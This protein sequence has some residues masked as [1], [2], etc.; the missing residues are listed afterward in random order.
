MLAKNKKFLF[1]LSILLITAMACSFSS[2][3]FGLAGR[4]AETVVTEEAVVVQ[5]APEATAEA[6]APIM[7]DSASV[8]AINQLTSGIYQAVSPGVVSILV[9]T[10][11]GSG[12]GS[13]FVYDKEGHIVTN[14]HVVDGAT[15][16][17]VDFQSGIKVW[18]DI[19]ATDPDSDLA[20]IKVDV[21]ADEL[22]P[23]TL[24]SSNDL[25]VGDTVL[26]IGNPYGLVGT[27]TTG[28]VSAKGRTMESQRLSTSGGYFSTGDIIQTDAS[29]NP[30][31]SGGPLLN[32]KGEVVGINRAIQTSGMTSTGDPVNTGIGFAISVDIVKRVVPVLI[33]NG[34]YEYPYLGISAL[35]EL[36]LLQQELLGITNNTGAYVTD[37]VA[38]SPADT[39]GVIGATATMVDYQGQQVEMPV[40]GDLIIAIDDQPVQVFG[41]LLSYILLNKVPGDT[42]TLTVIRGGETQTLSLVLGSRSSISN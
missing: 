40:G 38:G 12:S 4:L 18:A 36:N 30:G 22:V 32:L 23:L 33:S 5:E 3:P 13:G 2:L 37:V 6:S 19:I 10:D 24:G 27:M 16:V 15:Q 35:E 39:A 20:V 26:A 8:D 25:N 34:A 21:P 11:Q 14:Y 1:L 28:I 41:D 7:V 42:I 29:I 9:W 17:E 31:N